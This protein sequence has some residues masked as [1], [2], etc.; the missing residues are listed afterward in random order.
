MNPVKAIYLA[1]ACLI[2]M[3]ILL[4]ITTN[5]APYSAL[6]ILPAIAAAGTYTLS[7][8]IMW[9]WWQRNPPDLPTEVASL[10]QRFD[11]YRQLDL[12]GKR[13]FRRRT[14][15]IKEA[16]YLH[17]QAIDEFPEDVRIMVAASCATVTYHRSEYL[18][19]HFDT[20]IFY[21]HYFPT[22]LHEVLHCSELHEEDGAIIWTLNV[23][24]RSVIEPQK[25]LHLGL[26]E[27][28]RALF[29]YEP[30]LRTAL[31]ATAL[32]YEEIER[33]TQFTEVKLKE[34][35]GLP[36]LDLTAITNV[37]Y[38]THAAPF[39]AVAPAKAKAVNELVTRKVVP[40]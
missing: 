12:E 4:T 9:W 26:Y 22:P 38:H 8:Q 33:I 19:E 30:T 20:I 32:T 14:F 27:Y 37:L 16:T 3:G 31:E 29:Y 21:R 15:L 35:I 11:L 36:E 40:I 7:P 23:F 5:G 6:M 39:A 10:L 1:C 24:L 2:L 17:G 28:S 13:E 34:F 25:Y 18:L